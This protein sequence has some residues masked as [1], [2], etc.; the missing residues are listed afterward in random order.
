M[1]GFTTFSDGA[2]LRCIFDES[3]W[4]STGSVRALGTTTDGE[5]L[6]IDEFDFDIL[7]LDTWK[8]TVEFIDFTGF[9][10]IEFRGEGLHDIAA[11]VVRVVVIAATAVLIKVV[12]KT[13]ER[14]EG[15]SV[16]CDVVS[17]EERHF[18]CGCLWFE[19]SF[20][21]CCDWKS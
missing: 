13:E 16:V 2:R 21:S 19:N 17:W 7:L 4:W 15:R 10:D 11:A 9:L 18:A 3:G 20:D 14:V 8:F 6:V 1:I 12:K 5:G